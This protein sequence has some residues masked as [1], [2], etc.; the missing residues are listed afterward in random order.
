MGLFFALL[1]SKFHPLEKSYDIRKYLEL[2]NNLDLYKKYFNI[3]NKDYYVKY[4]IKLINYFQL[5]EEYLVFITSFLG[6]YFLY[7][8]YILI[9]NKK[10]SY[11]F[12]III[13]SIPLLAFSGIR[14]FLAS[15]ICI[16]GMVLYTF[17]KNSR[18]IIY[19]L[20]SILVHNTML[21]VFIIYILTLFIPKLN[22]N[23]Y[24][25]WL[26]LFFFF[27]FV[28]LD[29]CLIELINNFNSMVGKVYFYPNTYLD[30][31]SSKYTVNVFKSLNLIGFLFNYF[32]L[33]CR[34]I[35][36]F[37]YAYFSEK[38]QEKNIIY[39][40]TI[41][42]FFFQRYLIIFERFSFLV[43]LLILYFI[44]TE[45]KKMKFFNTFIFGTIVY[46]TLIYLY[47][48]KYHFINLLF[49]YKDIY[50]Y[51]LFQFLFM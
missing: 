24:L 36:L 43:N 51:S 30:S 7:K 40:I 17:K 29:R 47:D 46:D 20:F 8:V 9:V 26:I 3:S 12:F 44:S 35:L 34:K 18:G 42:I 28:K 14:F 45:K 11:Y 32:L 50:K 1:Q 33:Y 21:I 27:D 39:I 4:I 16:Y 10:K 23:I 25:P 15:S 48:F 2:L 22:F 37:F 13:F 31:D 5:K 38:K 6:Y 49:D 19:I 41:L